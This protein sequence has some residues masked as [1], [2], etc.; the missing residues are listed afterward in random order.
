MGTDIDPSNMED[1]TF[2]E[3]QS[4][5]DRQRAIQRAVRT[6]D[7][8]GQFRGF[9]DPLVIEYLDD[10]LPHLENPILV[11]VLR[12]VVAIAERECVEGSDYLA[13]LSA[14]DSR[15]RKKIHLLT[16]GSLSATPHCVMSYERTLAEPQ[17]AFSQLSEFLTGGTDAG[18]R[19]AVRR[20]IIPNA[21]MPEDVNFVEI[22]KLK[23]F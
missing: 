8:L 15:R 21:R 14:A 19:S 5:T 6:L 1:R 16:G 12:D 2:R 22:A 13:S 9:K 4:A 18:L 7:R 17:T 3:I 20:L 10:L 11:F 23:N